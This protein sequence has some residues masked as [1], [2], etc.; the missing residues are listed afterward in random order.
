MQS[1]GHGV[2][3]AVEIPP[4]VQDRE[5]DLDGGLLL[6]RIHGDGH[7]AAVVGDPDHAVSEQDDLDAV[8]VAG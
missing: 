7:A 6:L 2:G 1:A 4:G 8:G 3:V 5:D